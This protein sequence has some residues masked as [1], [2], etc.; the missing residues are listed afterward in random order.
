MVGSALAVAPGV[1]VLGCCALARVL[2]E[3]RGR[4][5]RNVG[6]RAMGQGIGE[7]RSVDNGCW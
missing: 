1:L 7:G 5:K 4:R 6:K 2:R 3:R